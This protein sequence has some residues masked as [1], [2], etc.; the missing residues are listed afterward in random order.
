M[1]SNDISK[2]FEQRSETNQSSD[3]LL[4]AFGFLVLLE[5][6]PRLAAWAFSGVNNFHSCPKSPQR[7]LTP[8][9]VQNP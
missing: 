9:Q 7:Q 1:T 4:S 2:Y 5:G 6:L 8:R 3:Q